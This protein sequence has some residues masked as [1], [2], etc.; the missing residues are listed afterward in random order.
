MS[1]ADDRTPPTIVLVILSCGKEC[2]GEYTASLAL[3]PG[4]WI[5]IFSTI[6]PVLYW[7]SLLYALVSR[8]SIR[9]LLHPK[10]ASSGID[11]LSRGSGHPVYVHTPRDARAWHDE[12]RGELNCRSL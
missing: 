12:E 4:S 9:K 3:M 2:A 5:K 11:K 6:L 7:Q 8:H 10:L 1:I